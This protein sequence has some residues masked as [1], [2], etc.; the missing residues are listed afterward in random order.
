M[1]YNFSKHSVGTK[2][3]FLDTVNEQIVD[4]DINLPDYCPDIEKILKCTLIPKVYTRSISGGQ[5]TIDGVSTVRI[6]YCDSVRHNIRSF[7]QSVPFTATFNLK[8]TPEQYVVLTDT[9][10]EYLNCRALSPRKLVV[11]GAFSL[12]AKVIC[13]SSTDFY[14]LQE[15]CDLQIKC[16]GITASD[17]CAVCQEQFSLTEDINIT[18]KPPVQSLLTYDVSACIT[19]LKS[20]SNKL[21]LSGELNLKVMYLSDLDIG[22]VEH[23]SYVFPV[24]RII[25]CDGVMDDTVNVPYLEV[26][27]HDLQIRNDSL[28]DGSLLSLDVKLCFS[29]LC[30]I[31]E[32]I[33]IIDDVY[34]VTCATQEKRTPMNFDSNHSSENLT[35]IVKSTVTL[36]GVKISKVLD[37]YSDALALTPVVSDSALSFSGK[38]NL[39]IL[40]EDSEGTPS[41]IERSTDILFKPDI[42]RDFDRAELNSTDVRSIS[43]RLVDDSTIE[44][45]TEFRVSVLFLNCVHLNPVTSVIADED[46]Q[47]ERDDCSLI[48]YFADKGE[49]TWDIAKHYKTKEGALIEEN[50]L[51]DAVIDSSRMIFVPTK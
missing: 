9:K 19:E 12:Y 41:Y 8:S 45:R 20:I 42:A 7:S 22:K 16:R 29:S 48:L 26:M 21:M 1:E 15:E 27:S 37:I 49:N 6:L 38:T 2:S 31:S 14:S 46:A 43:Y 18:T 47:I 50:N 40:I 24:S 10:C 3:A 4:V 44:I 51:N 36:D 39:C 33:N 28:N 11:H 5:L 30:Y 35:H 23:I 34:S 32:N 17:L 25:D 13:R